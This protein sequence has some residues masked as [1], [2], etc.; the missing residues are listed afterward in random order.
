ML[1]MFVGANPG[2]TGGGIK[3]TTAAV[4]LVAVWAVAR[5]H[6]RP[7]LFRRH[8]DAALITRVAAYQDFIFSHVPELASMAEI[9][10]EP[11]HAASLALVG[12]L[13]ARRRL[14]SS[15]PER[16]Q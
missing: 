9:V 5:G 4:L 10:P 2:S 14:P 3:T 11:A 16:H 15:R 7:A 12:L 1:L 8:I 6:N 13:A